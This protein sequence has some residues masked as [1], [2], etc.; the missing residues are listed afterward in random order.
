MVPEE[1]SGSLAEVGE[2]AFPIPLALQ[3]Y[4][5][6]REDNVLG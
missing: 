6:M 2:S 4:D 1:G 5:E 3:V